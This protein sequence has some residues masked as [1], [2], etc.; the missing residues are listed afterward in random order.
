MGQKHWCRDWLAALLVADADLLEH[1]LEQG[2]SYPHYLCL[3]NMGRDR[4]G[5]NDYE[6]L[7]DRIRRTPKKQMLEAVLDP[8][9]DGL[10]GALKNL[11]RGPIP[12]PKDYTRLLNLM[13]EPHT[14]KFLLHGSEIS[15]VQL[16][17]LEK[18]PHEL[19]Q[20]SVIRTIH[21]Q[22]DMNVFMKIIDSVHRFTPAMNY[23]NMA[24]SL[25]HVSQNGRPFHSWYTKQISKKNFPD[26]PWP[27]NDKVKPITSA[28]QL[29]HVARTMRN[30]IARV[31]CCKFSKASVIFM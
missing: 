20:C 5:Y 24:L 19:R 11:H 8:C 7:A 30:C 26:P 27:G 12:C 28:T 4:L 22:E 3:I 1:I 14:R 29:R 25:R 13:S 21:R 10:L 16:Q 2:S 18:L 15:P 31:T 9:P 17:L 23:A 6:D